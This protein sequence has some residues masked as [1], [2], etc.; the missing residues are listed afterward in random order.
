MGFSRQED[1]N[2]LPLPS[3]GGSS[4]PRGWAWVSR[5]AGGF[6][7]VWAAWEASAGW[8][9][10]P[11]VLLHACYSRSVL[12]L[13][14][15]S[16]FNDLTSQSSE[17]WFSPINP[18]QLLL[19]IGVDKLSCFQFWFHLWF[20]NTHGLWFVGFSTQLSLHS[21]ILCVVWASSSLDAPQPQDARQLQ[22][23][24]KT[25]LSFARFPC[26]EVLSRQHWFFRIKPSLDSGCLWSQGT[27]FQAGGSVLRCCHLSRPFPTAVMPC[28]VE[29]SDS[30]TICVILSSFLS[31]LCPGVA[32]GRS[33]AGGAYVDFT[34][35]WVDGLNQLSLAFSKAELSSTSTKMSS[36]SNMPVLSKYS[37]SGSPSSIFPLKINFLREVGLWWL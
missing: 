6:L 5:T 26:S 10:I 12:M 9:L 2:G 4:L 24:Q 30:P 20:S 13:Q 15:Y 31:P 19:I 18:L 21:L 17:F 3:P 34:Y 32:L 8:A 14:F 25:H 36:A 28:A 1:W 16:M 23:E 22:L 27:P 33:W 29:R 11:S 7:T 37:D 35:P